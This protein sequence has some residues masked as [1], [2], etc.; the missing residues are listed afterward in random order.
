MQREIKTVL[1]TGAVCAGFLAMSFQSIPSG[2]RRPLPG[3]DPEEKAGKRQLETLAD[4]QTV[5][6]DVRLVLHMEDGEVV[7]HIPVAVDMNADQYMRKDLEGRENSMGAV[8]MDEQDLYAVNRVIYGHASRQNNLRFTFLK[9]YA[10]T[11]FYQ[12]H[13]TFLVED[14]N[15]T[16]LYQIVS[17]ASYDLTKEDTY[18]GWSLP[19][20]GEEGAEG[21]FRQT[22]PYLLQK[23]DGVVYAGQQIMTLVTC[24]MHEEDTRFVLQALACLKE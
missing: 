11:T 12:Q 5:N 15:S 6:P 24:S 2:V 3:M 14:E 8:F 22:L 1:L 18:T 17:F 4:W 13:P 20:F 21:M 7:R 10:S 19:S 16:T 9:Q 23:T